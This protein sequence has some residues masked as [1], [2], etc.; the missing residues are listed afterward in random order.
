MCG[1]FVANASH[2]EH[3]A[4][5]EIM[6]RATYM[7]VRKGEETGLFLEYIAWCTPDG[8]APRSK[9]ENVTYKRGDG[10]AGEAWKRMRPVIEDEFKQGADQNWVDNYPDQG[11]KYKSMI[12][13]PVLRSDLQ[14]NVEVLGVVTVDTNIKRYFGQKGNKDDEERG[15]EKIRPY[16]EY[17]SF[18]S[19]ISDL[20]SEITSLLGRGSVQSRT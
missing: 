3:M 8:H 17:I 12:C 20:G 4:I 16:A 14:A 2:G 7:E 18:A 9:S 1:T 5:P 6:F 11:T 15:G 19:T 10:V 13:V